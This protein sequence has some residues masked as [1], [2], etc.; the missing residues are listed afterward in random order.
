MES[1]KEAQVSPQTFSPYSFQRTKLAS[2]TILF[3]KWKEAQ[4]YRTYENALKLQQSDELDEAEKCYLTLLK[5]PLLKNLKEV[6][7]T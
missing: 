3:L 1:K 6:R 7:R 5:S 2:L 4:D